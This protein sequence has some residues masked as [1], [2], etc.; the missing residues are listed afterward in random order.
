MRAKFITDIFILGCVM[1]ITFISFDNVALFQS[2]MTFTSH[3]SHT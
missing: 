2:V 3:F 1:D